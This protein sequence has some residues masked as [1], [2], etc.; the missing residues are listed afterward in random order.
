MSTRLTSYALAALCAAPLFGCG[1]AESRGSVMLAI[2]TDM[3]VNKD[4]DR[5]DIIVQPESGRA[6]TVP[7]NL[8]P[9]TGGLYLPGTFSIVEGS[10]PGEFVR[11]R[12]V[13]RKGDDR[14]RVV[15]EA[16][17]RIPRERTALLPMPIQW[18]CDGHVKQVDEL[19]RSDCGEGETCI[20][21]SCQPDLVEESQLP[22][23]RA[24]D[25]FGGG[26]AT[27]GGECFD[28]LRCF[29]QSNAPELDTGSCVL[30][31]TPDDDLNVA[32]VLPPGSDGHCTAEQCWIPLDASPLTGWTPTADGSGVQLPSG[33]CSLVSAGAASV[34]VSRSCAVK[35]PSTPTCGE[36]TLVGS[37]PGDVP[38]APP[39]TGVPSALDAEL[40]TLA[41]RLAERVA[42]S[43]AS[44][45][46]LSP[47][48]DPSEVELDALCQQAASAVAPHAPLS[49]FHL[50]ARCTPDDE[51]QLACEATCGACQPGT[52]LERC[53]ANNFLSTCSTTCESRRCLGSANTATQCA[54][55]CDGQLVGQCQG[56]CFGTCEG[57][58][59]VLTPDGRCDGAC[60]GTCL[61]LCVGRGTGSCYGLCDGDPMLPA[62]ACSTGSLC[63]GSCTGEMAGLSCASRLIN[64]PCAADGCV[65]DCGALG[66]IDLDCHRASSWLLPPEGMDPSLV[67][68]LEAALPDLLSVRDAEGPPAID[69]S[70]R[71]IDR[72][73]AAPATPLATVQQAQAA[74]SLLTAVRTSAS[75]L[76]DALGPPRHQ[77]FN[78]GTP[79][80]APPIAQ[81]NTCE[82]YTSPGTNGLIDDFE[83]GDNFLLSN[84]GRVGAW[85]IGQDGTGTLEQSEP[86]LPIA[87]GA[88][89]SNFALRL[90]GSGFSNWG[91]N[92]FFELRAGSSPYD[93]SV[94]Q[95]LK[96]WAR[97]SGQLRV[98]LTQQSL[99]PAHAC[100]TCLP[101]SGECGQFYSA[102]VFLSSTWSEIILDWSSFAPPTTISTPLRPAQLM[103]IEFEAPA[104]EPVDFW[105]DDVAFN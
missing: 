61:G 2:S 84:D 78:G 3:S 80:G 87:G 45:A 51:R 35:V 14:A 74:L 22:D 60:E 63:L 16:A 62:G 71:L 54:G 30:A 13:A 105:L 49:W 91:A 79:I 98:I 26:S 102:V 1:Q 72:L 29:E 99:A 92:V 24:E 27:G 32:V 58:C 19:I 104:P 75:V 67:A 6:Q 34:R 28:T 18:L 55:A 89:D 82:P 76:I 42:R 96:F 7:V 94:H 33:L 100:S 47:P 86:P 59:S 48:A 20:S 8:Y 9:S 41:T 66:R 90:S 40:R 83:D 21:G 11:V 103:K 97:G 50:P 15:R 52:V 85:H 101:E 17:L 5:V 64:S 93:A 77:P 43:C 57:T 65:G 31:T 23:Y 73:T 81:P 38:T 4:L 56:N 69:E 25:V 12:I 53:D 88:N 95:G 68:S 36:W 37:E 46:Q 39:V 70:S 10:Q 44:V